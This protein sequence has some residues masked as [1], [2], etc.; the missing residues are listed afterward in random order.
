MFSFAL[1]RFFL[2]SNGSSLVQLSSPFAPVPTATDSSMWDADPAVPITNKRD[3]Q[4]FYLGT[5]EA[6]SKVENANLSIS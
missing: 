4:V 3:C 5:C 2:D 1:S 6:H